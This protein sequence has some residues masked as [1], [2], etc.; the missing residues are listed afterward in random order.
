MLGVSVDTVRRWELDGRLQT[1][2]SSGGQRLIAI[3]EVARLLGLRRGPEPERSIT[4]QSARSRFPSIVTNVARDNVVAVVELMAG[5]HRLVSLMTA[6]AADELGIA[7]GLRVIAVIKA[8]DVI[9]EIPA[10]KVSSP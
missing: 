8:T 9:V 6:E 1:L 4:A 5:P 2:R 7:V 3:D 10:A